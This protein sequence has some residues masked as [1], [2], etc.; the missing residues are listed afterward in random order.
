[1]NSLQP[2]ITNH[3]NDIIQKYTSSLFRNATLE[4]YGI[5]TAP[6]KEL[7]NPELPVVEVSGGA[8]DM[9]FLLEDD[10]YLH[11][12]FV[13]GHDSKKAMLKCV[14]Y[15]TRLYE[16]DERLVNTAVIYTAD[17][18]KKPNALNIGTL[19]YDPGVILMADYDGDTTFTEL[20]NKIKSNQELS[21]TDVLRLV[22]LPL[23]SHTMPR[24]ELASSA[25]AL[26]KTISDQQKKDACIAATFA[27]ASKYL[28]EEKLENLKEV[29]EMTGLAKL[30]IMD[31][32]VAI[33]RDMIKDGEPLAKI[34][35][36]S[37]LSES[38][39]LKLQEEVNDELQTAT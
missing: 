39:I 12:A 30:F 35:K 27:F 7:I 10:T 33:A 2:K 19:T 4:F 25:I 6:I 29:L 31:E 21:D 14:G 9:V 5:K 11:L 13:T 38:E 23:M 32:R 8:A 15:D 37:R 3:V 28:D 22:L 34:M 17:V 18:K 16:R 36:Y 1:V 20:Q 26:A 24:Y